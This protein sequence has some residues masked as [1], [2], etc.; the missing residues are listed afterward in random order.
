MNKKLKTRIIAVTSALA[1][2]ASLFAA[3]GGS[4]NLEN[5]MRAKSSSSTIENGTITFN[6]SDTTRSSYTY[7]TVSETAGGNY[8][9]SV[10]TSNGLNTNGVVAYFAYSDS[11]LNFRNNSNNPF[12]FSGSILKS[13]AL[14]KTEWGTFSIKYAYK[15]SGDSDYTYSSAIDLIQS[16]EHVIELG[17]LSDV[18]EFKLVNASSNTGKFSKVVITYDCGP[19]ISRTLTDLNITKAPNKVVYNYGESFDSTGMI[20]TASYSNGD[21]DNVTSS[22]VFDKTILSYSDNYVRATYTYKGVSLYV[23]QSVTVNTVPVTGVSLSSK[24]ETINVGSTTTL[25]ANIAPSNAS[26]KSVTWSSSDDT[27][28]TVSNGVVTGVA[29]GNAI[30]TVTTND[31]G[32]TDTCE[33]TV[34]GISRLGEYKYTSGTSYTMQIFLVDSSNGYYRFVNSTYDCTMHFTYVIDGYNIVFTKNQQPGDSSV[35]SGSWYDLFTGSSGEAPT[36]NNKCSFYTDTGNMKVY[37]C[38]N[39]TYSGSSKSFKKQAA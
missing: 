6:G 22:C 9:K 34:E 17:E 35:S 26:D 12:N 19:G 18:V 23:D 10:G 15:C 16:K 30:I 38:S 36:V 25:T 13:V 37:T 11:D 3:F 4:F 27:I 32:F 7:T 31:G 33:V 8:I 28:A 24:S 39:S 2:S 21:T 14:T 1:L 20:I 29:A 5:I